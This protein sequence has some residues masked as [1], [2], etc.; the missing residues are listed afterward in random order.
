MVS[1]YARTSDDLAVDVGQAEIAAR[2]AVGELLVIEAKLLKN[3]GMEVVDRNPIF[4]GFETELF[5]LTTYQLVG[6]I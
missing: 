5:R 3:R 2:V 6:I 4:D 1:D